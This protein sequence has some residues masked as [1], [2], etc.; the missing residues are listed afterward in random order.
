MAD[1]NPT[2][3]DPVGIQNNQP[4]EP[5]VL[6]P[7][8]TKSPF[9]TPEE[10][11]TNPQAVTASG[12]ATDL[13]TNPSPADPLITTS[14]SESGDE[15]KSKKVIATILGIVL[16][17]AAVGTGVFLVGQQQELRIGAWDC[18]NYVFKV[19]QNGKVSALNGSTRNEPLQKA[20][21]FINGQQVAT[22]D[23]PALVAGDAAEICTVGV[24]NSGNFSWEVIGTKDCEDSGSFQTTPTPSPTLTP[25]PSPTPTDG[26]TPSSS[27]SPTPSP[28]PTITPTPPPIGA[29]C[30]DVKTYN[31][32]FVLLSSSELSKLIPGDI[33]RFAV[34]GT[35]TQGGFDKARFTINGTLQPEVTAQKPGSDEFYIEYTIPAGITNFTVSAEIHHTSLD[36][37]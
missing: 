17:I 24:P 33:V 1:K 29:A 7:V 3:T 35:T 11:P 30:L 25:T 10:P 16:L 21:V 6:P 9:S 34:A 37:F 26:P 27:P 31:T 28:T 4:T 2:D 8:Q 13:G 14:S 22:C 32:N 15:S 12:I 5:P 23:V 20:N 18:Q 36:W 19:S